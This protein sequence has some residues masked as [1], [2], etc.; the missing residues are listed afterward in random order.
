MKINKKGNFGV[1]LFAFFFTLTIVTGILLFFLVG[2]P[3]ILYEYGLKQG[4][5][6]SQELV[7]MGVSNAAT[8]SSITELAE[9]YKFI[10]NYADYLFIF[11]IIGA[12]IQSIISAVKLPR[13]GIMSF[14]GLITLGNILL[15]FFLGF[16]VEINSWIVNEIVYGVVLVAT[17]TG[18]IN[19]FFEYNMFIVTLWFTL[20][21]VL[22]MVNIDSIRDRIPFMSKSG[23]DMRFEQ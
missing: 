18:F 13:A 19:W 16:A 3:A 11:F 23:E 5:S 12:F 6:V 8:H 10:Y 7:D 1:K 9:S 21:V 2:L 22:N 14:F 4:V 20:L 17:E 15:L